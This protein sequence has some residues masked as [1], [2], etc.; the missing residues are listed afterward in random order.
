M[1]FMGKVNGSIW[2]MQPLTSILFHIVWLSSN[3]QCDLLG[4]LQSHTLNARNWGFMIYHFKSKNIKCSVTLILC[5]FLSD[6]LLPVN[7]GQSTG[8]ASLR[9]LTSIVD[10]ITPEHSPS[11][12]LESN[13]INWPTVDVLPSMHLFIIGSLFYFYTLWCVLCIRLFN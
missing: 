8:S 6:H 9:S 2:S 1:A 12:Y 7:K 5:C 4:F 13:T 3:W 11:S 10:N